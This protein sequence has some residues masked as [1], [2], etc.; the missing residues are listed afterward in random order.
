MY[1][2]PF[3]A[4][5]HAGHAKAPSAHTYSRVA[6]ETGVDAASPHKLVAMLFDGYFESLMRAKAAMAAGDVAMKGSEISRAVRII[7]EGLKASLDLRAGGTLARDLA[8]LYAYITVR[9]TQANLRNDVTALEECR[10]LVKPLQD[11]WQAI[12]PSVAHASV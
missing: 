1:A 12:A 7:E 3:A 11:A 5:P 6:V 2:S 8:D 10:A 9:L 4:S